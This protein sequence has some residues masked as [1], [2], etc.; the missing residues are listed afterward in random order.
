[1]RLR[2][3]AAGVR[4]T[5][6]KTDLAL[7]LPG[8]TTSSCQRVEQCLGLLQDRR[9]Q[10]LR[11]PGVG[12]CEE[13]TGGVALALFEPEPGETCRGAQLPELRTLLLG[14][15][16]GL[17]KGALR[18]GEV[19]AGAQQLPPDPMQLRLGPPLLSLGHQPLALSE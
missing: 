18:S 12:L 16:N 14:N 3:S 8:A 13:I 4:G 15:A 2:P 6:T 19:A 1:M 7:W 11:E 17:G 10:A 5:L 9:V